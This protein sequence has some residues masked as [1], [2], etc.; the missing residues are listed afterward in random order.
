MTVF[1]VSLVDRAKIDDRHIVTY[2]REKAGVVKGDDDFEDLY[3]DLLEEEVRRE[4]GFVAKGADLTFALRPLPANPRDA[5]TDPV[6]HVTTYVPPA[7]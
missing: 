4:F 7:L 6:I 5:A 3:D 1:D 2:L